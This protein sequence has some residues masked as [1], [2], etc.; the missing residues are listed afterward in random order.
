[1]DFATIGGLILGIAAM[2]I[3]FW[4]EGGSILS[5][6]S[7]TAFIIVF[8]GTIGATVISFSIEEIKKIPAFLKQACF[9]Q[10]YDLHGLIQEMVH[11]ANR[12][13]REGLLSL[14]QKLKDIED[15]FVRRGLQM[16]VDGVES[17]RLRDMLETEIYCAKQ[18]QKVGIE[19]FETAGGY[20]PTMGIIG[21][22][23]GLVNVLGHM[24][25]PDELGHSIAVAFIATLYGVGSANLMWLPIA[26]KLKVRSKKQ[27]LYKELALEGIMSLQAGEA[28][29]LM[30]EKLLAFIDEKER[31]LLDEKEG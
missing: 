28:S 2:V 22:V 4:L 29:S 10:H 3:G 17:S 13:R 26:G 14:E 1:M 5:L 6:A 25:N 12:A 20:A 31:D 27:V 15:P 30:K 16:V 21:T 7:H 19:I 23:M 8:G 11:L 18:R 9:V 24:N